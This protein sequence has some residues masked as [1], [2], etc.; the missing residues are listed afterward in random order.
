[1]SRTL[2]DSI[3]QA[4]QDN[5]ISLQYTSLKYDGNKLNELEFVLSD[6]NHTGAAKTNFVNKIKPFGFKVDRR[7]GA[8]L[9]FQVGELNGY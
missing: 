9:T 5:G 6:G 1:M 2:L 3:S 4:V 8:T 7:P